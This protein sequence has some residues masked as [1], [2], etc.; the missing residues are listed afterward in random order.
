VPDNRPDNSTLTVFDHLDREV[1]NIEFLNSKTTVLRGMF[2]YPG[3]RP[4][5]ITDQF[6]NIHG[7]VMSR[8]CSAEAIGEGF[9]I[10]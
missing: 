4:I 7:I 8:G 9:R 5:I 10:E 6:S 2:R 3:T 1:L